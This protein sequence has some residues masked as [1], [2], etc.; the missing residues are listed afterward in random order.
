MIKIGSKITRIDSMF[1]VIT[2]ATF[3]TDAGSNDMRLFLMISHKKSGIII[4][5][6]VMNIKEN[7]IVALRS[8]ESLAA[9]AAPRLAFQ[10]FQNKAPYKIVETIMEGNTTTAL[11]AFRNILQEI[12]HWLEAVH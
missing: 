9:G 4:A 11:R 5:N 12:L 6:K 8:L 7:V 2:P 3:W 10:A 1:P